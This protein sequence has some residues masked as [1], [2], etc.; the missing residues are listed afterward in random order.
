MEISAVS[1]VSLRQIDWRKLTAKE[2]IKYEQQGVEVPNEYLQWAKQ[3]Q[4]DLNSAQNDDTTYE[5][6][7]GANANA[8][9][10][11]TTATEEVQEGE[12]E[13]VSA[14]DRRDKMLQDGASYISVTRTFS[15]ESVVKS[16]ESEA[17]ANM[18]TDIGSSSDSRV[19]TLES[20][21]DSLMAQVDELKSQIDSLKNKK[22]S[23]GLTNMT[24]IKQLE[25]QLRALGMQGQTMA[26]GADADLNEYNSQIGAQ[27]ELNTAN[28]DH[29]S[30]TKEMGENVKK[31]NWLLGII[32]GRRAVKNGEK[33]IGKGDNAIKVGS[34]IERQ[35]NSNLSQVRKLESEIASKT[36]AGSVSADN[37]DAASK[38]GENPNDP[39]NQSEEQQTKDIAASG[40]I[41]EVLQYKVRKGEAEA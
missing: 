6:A 20:S 26:A 41:N 14:S 13:N 40:N 38:D 8:A 4:A 17:S 21:I 19:E 28:I 29:G 15:A 30:V 31:R 25:R 39:A 12:E 37:S 32:V 27:G 24:K 7:A 33:A 3:F 23:D 9:S 2:I 34:D 1:G 16:R 18:L 22:D 36:G 35:N 5:M 11:N 10:A